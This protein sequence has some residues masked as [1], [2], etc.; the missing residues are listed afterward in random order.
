[1]KKII[2]IFLVFSVMSFFSIPVRAQS[3][4]DAP[5]IGKGVNVITS[6]YAN[7]TSP[8]YGSQIFTDNYWNNIAQLQ[9]VN[10]DMTI[11]DVQKGSSINSYYDQKSYT[12]QQE[13]GVSGTYKMFN[14]TL[15]ANFSE[16]FASQDYRKTGQYYYTYSLLRQ[17]KL[18]Y[19]QNFLDNKS[20]FTNNLSSTFL[21]HLYLLN[22]GYM[23][24][25]EFF[26]IYGTHFIA[27]GIY[28]GRIDISYAVTTDEVIFNTTQ[29]N[30]I[31]ADIAAGI[32]YT[33]NQ[34]YLNTAFS[35]SNLS[36]LSSVDVNY[37]YKMTAIGGSGFSSSTQGNMSSQYVNWFEDIEDN[38]VIIGYGTQGLV[39]L[40]EIIPASYSNVRQN[41]ANQFL[42]YANS[43]TISNGSNSSIVTSQSTIRTAT[44]TIN[45]TGRFVHNKRD[46]INLNK[47]SSLYNE[48]YLF[49]RGIRN[50][51]ILI[52]I[53]V[54]EVWD[55]YQYIFL[56]NNDGTE[57]T[58]GSALGEI[59]FEHGPG[60]I[61][62]QEETYHFEF[63]VPLSSIGNDFV[64]RYGASGAGWDDWKNWDLKVS[65]I[66]Y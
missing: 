33:S 48:A 47:W 16:S 6:T 4:Q 1:M 38:P 21:S 40:W 52:T 34:G 22:N 51:R 5:G 27:Q 55:G 42:A 45:D 19:I 56:Y 43:Y 7:P 13:A 66:F 59:M 65:L 26:G 11:E 44:Y 15:S 39:P 60:S 41:M 24:Y 37:S 12:Y 17:E 25:P 64:I 32:V 54:K 49:N 50:V 20:Q 61:K 10:L 28:G 14:G 57:S 46:I 23:T 8:I 63:D 29:T 18:V 31:S 53:T 2:F 3:L 30:E 62:T 35:I 58:S 36:S 9:S